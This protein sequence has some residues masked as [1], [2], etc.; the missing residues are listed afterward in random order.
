MLHVHMDTVF[1]QFNQV[2]CPFFIEFYF[3][4]GGLVRVLCIFW[5][6]A[7]WWLC[8]TYPCP[9]CGMPF[10]SYNRAFWRRGALILMCSN[11]LVFSFVINVIC[12]M[13]KKFFFF[14]Q[15]VGGILCYFWKLDCFIFHVSIYS[16]CRISWR[17]GKLWN[18]GLLPAPIE[19]LNQSSV[20]NSILS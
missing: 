19:K 13:L 3:F 9:P 20:E 10:C 1:E 15:A 2:S 8:Y 14:P 18:K 5:K 17:L 16:P 6:R 12:V 4:G 11:S 7:L